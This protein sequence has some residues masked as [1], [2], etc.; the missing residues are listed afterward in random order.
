MPPAVNQ[1]SPRSRV[2]RVQ[3]MTSG[4]RTTRQTPLKRVNETKI[5]YRDTPAEDEFPS[6]RGGR[7]SARGG[8]RS[9]LQQTIIGKGVEKSTV[10]VQRASSSERVWRRSARGWW[11]H[12]ASG[13]SACGCCGGQRETGTYRRNP[14]VG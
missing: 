1:S 10:E 12:V 8:V 4:R 14:R 5:A 3:S 7:E 13:G 11:P 2:S 9:V 6:R